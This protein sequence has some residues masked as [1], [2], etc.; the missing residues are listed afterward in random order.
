MNLQSNKKRRRGRGKGVEKGIESSNIFTFLEYVGLEEWDMT[1]FIHV[2]LLRESQETGSGIINS[3]TYHK[4][5]PQ[6]ANWFLPLISSPRLSVTCL[7]YPQF[8]FTR[9][10]KRR[11]EMTPQFLKTPPLFPVDRKGWKR[12]REGSLACLGESDSPFS[13]RRA[14]LSLSLNL[15]C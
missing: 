9:K 10:R 1:Y 3:S 15:A 2:S 5:S 14:S 11:S 12:V 4:P 6:W 8:S 7:S 13:T